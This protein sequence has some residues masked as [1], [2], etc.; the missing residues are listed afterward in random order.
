V[1][2]LASVIYLRPSSTV[3][4]KPSPVALIDKLPGHN[5]A[6]LILSD[7]RVVDLDK[8]KPGL[9]AAQGNSSV[10][11]TE[12][13]KLVYETGKRSFNVAINTLETPAGGQ[14]PIVLSDGTKIFLNSISRLDFPEQ[15]DAEKRVVRF[16]G[17]GY[18]EVAKDSFRPFFVIINGQEIRVT[19]TKFV[20]SAYADERFT[21][22]TLVEGGIKVSNA[23]KDRYAAAVSLSINPQSITVRP[24]QALINDS[25]KGFTLDKQADI[26]AATAFTKGQFVLNS[27]PVSTALRQ[28]GRWYDLEIE[29]ENRQSFD[30]VIISA[31]FDKNQNLSEVMKILKA[32][33]VNTRLQGNKLIVTK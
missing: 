29:Y 33:G 27:A 16:A 13:G 10:S 8:T 31:A 24:G 14:Y 1:V 19:G 12:D 26:E 4:Q 9:I 25:L 20:I 3:E 2:V 30:D 5:N 28:F 17:E 11:K 23:P 22:T 21:M 6:R 15:F 18:F 7:G 32:L